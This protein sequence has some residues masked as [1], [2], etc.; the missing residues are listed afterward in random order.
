MAQNTKTYSIVINGIKESV[1][2]VDTLLAKLNELDARVKNLNKGNIKITI[3]GG[4]SGGKAIKDTQ[5]EAETATNTLA[6]M[7]K[8]LSKLKKE[9]ANTE[10][11]TDEFE[12]LRKKTKEVND[13]VKQVEQSYGV[14]SRNVGN[15]TNSFISAFDKFPQE[16]KNTISGLKSFNGDAATINQQMKSISKSMEELT[17]NGQENSEAYKAL[18]SVYSELAQKQAD[19]NDAI[20]DAKDRSGGLKDVTEIFS[21]LTG[22]M[23][24][25]AGAASL[26]G[27]NGEDAVKAIQKMQALQSI[28]NGLKSLQAS[29]QRNGALWKVWQKS[30]SGADKILGVFPSKVK[31]TSTSMAATTTATQ[32]ATTA[33]K[34]LR[35]AIASTGIGVLVVALGALVAAFVKMSDSVEDGKKKLESFG[36]YVE[37]RLNDQLSIISRKREL[38]EISG[39]EEAQMKLEAYQKGLDGYLGKYSDLQKTMKG[40][41]WSKL[42]DE[43]SDFSQRAISYIGRKTGLSKAFDDVSD[44]Y[45]KMVESMGHTYNFNTDEAAKA[46]Q[47]LEKIFKNPAKD[48]EGLNKQ[49]EQLRYNLQA[50]ENDGSEEA[51]AAVTYTNKVIDKMNDRLDAIN[52]IRV[53]E[54][55][56]AENIRQWNID[57]MAD[58]YSKQVAQIEEN[59]RKEQEKYQGNSEAILALEKKKQS[60]LNKVNREWATKRL[61]IESQILNNELS[62]YKNNLDLR[63]KQLNIE[64]QKEISIARESGIEVAR[65]IASINAKYDQLITD[66]KNKIEIEKAKLQKDLRNYFAS[67]STSYLDALQ[68]L[69]Q[70]NMSLSE[71]LFDRD[72]FLRNIPK[73]KAIIDELFNIFRDSETV[74]LT[75]AK[76]WREKL[77]NEF[78][79]SKDSIDEIMADIANSMS[80][81]LD[82]AL[83]ENFKMPENLFSAIGSMD[84]NAVDEVITNMIEQFNNFKTVMNEQVEGKVGETW[85][86]SIVG[87]ISLVSQGFYDL[88]LRYPELIDSQNKFYV[89]SLENF[90]KYIREQADKQKEYAD[91]ELKNAKQAYK[92]EYD[93]QVEALNE[94]NK[95]QEDEL[96]R[97]LK[98][99]VISQK[100]YNTQMQELEQNNV[101][102]MALITSTYESNLENAETIHK[103]K[104]ISINNDTN[105]QVKSLTKSYLDNLLLQHENYFTQVETQLTQF[106]RHQYNNWNIVNFGQMSKELNKAKQEYQNFID[107]MTM[108]KEIL[109]N[110]LSNGEIDIDTYTEY[111]QKIENEV[112]EKVNAIEDI[113]SDLK[114]LPGELVNS[115]NTYV[116]T[117]INGIS[118]I[119][120]AMFDKT[121]AD[122]DYQMEILENENDR[123]EKLLDKQVDMIEKHN[124]KINDIEGELGSARG[125]RRDQLIQAYNAEQLARE[126]AYAQ[127]KKIEKEKEKNEKKQRELEKKQNKERHKQQLLQAIV[128]TALATANGLATQPFLP[129]GVAMGALATALGAVQIGI[130]QSTKYASGGQLDG[131]VAQGARHSQGGIKVL[132]GR[133]EI[134][135]GEYITNRQSTKMNMPLLEYIN[136]QKHRVNLNELIEFYSD[137]NNAFKNG[138]VIR[139]KFAEGGQL[140]T[141]SNISMPQNNNRIVVQSDDKPIYVS[142]TEFE[143]V[144]GRMARVKELAGW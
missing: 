23:Q 65:Q 49:I 123:L 54:K 92:N 25:A 5:E 18:K 45:T 130:I 3:G 2:Q 90:D 136:S 103:T 79:I 11:G 38:G 113:N 4:T 94:R 41:F 42:G 101:A 87:S 100:E 75:F 138:G 110:K 128:S 111:Y 121:N 81:R 52:S 141:M 56:L 27:K 8:E 112:R 29:L 88:N 77:V 102:A 17:A 58:G 135:G 7:R 116:Q 71:A 85:A 21:S 93:E 36:N 115:I 6:G 10:I 139:E 72:E 83:G 62:V 15:Y 84:S 91:Q 104:I 98:S 126:K 131:G 99:R 14:F 124:D 73:N 127:Q 40:G 48:A 31:A 108:L 16:V 33:M 44:S 9:L 57:S 51:D 22:A 19:F 119:M 129:V 133:A 1:E 26:F 114:Q 97:Q 120:T 86:E 106:K 39:L 134:E 122:L 105:N 137:K 70:N 82:R 13:Q 109:D 24:L 125:D 74:S 46:M 55:E 68:N 96:N 76:D 67:L 107:G 117:A 140:P 95:L 61:N 37:G 30:L 78:G 60:E 32:G 59:F 144:Q 28:A 66:E 50:L 69:R 143:Q 118:Q 34:G 20:D 43:I 132:G 35:V 89:K 47:E 64:R 80:E 12:K 142:V 53:A 63:I